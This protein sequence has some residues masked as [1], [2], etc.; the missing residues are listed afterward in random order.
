MPFKHDPMPTTDQEIKKK[1]MVKL[2]LYLASF[3]PQ[4]FIFG[5][6][7]TVLLVAV[8]TRAHTLTDH[9]SINLANGLR[10][11]DVSEHA[12]H[13]PGY[14]LVVFTAHLF[15]FLGS[16]L[17]ALQAV[18]I[19]SSVIAILACW[20]LAR[21]LFGP[22]AGIIAA[23]LLAGTPLFLYYA[24]IASVY[25]PEAAAA[26]LLTLLAARVSRRA[27]SLDDILLPVALAIAAGFRPTTAVL[28]APTVLLG[29]IIGRPPV[30]HLLLGGILMLGLVAT[31][32]VP[33]LI[34][35][36]GIEEYRQATDELWRSS[37]SKTSVFYGA[38]VVANLKNGLMAGLATV[39]VALP[40]LLLVLGAGKPR[41]GRLWSRE[42]LFLVAWIVPYA[43]LYTLFFFG[44][45]GYVLAYAPAFACVAAASVSHRHRALPV[46]AILAATF[47]GAFMFLPEWPVPPRVSPFL[48]SAHRIAVQDQ[49]AHALQ[50]IARSCPPSSCLIVSLPGEQRYYCHDPASLAPEYGRGA[51]YVRPNSLDSV[52]AV[53][54]L[55]VGG[56]PPESVRT[57]AEYLGQA[58]SWRI[59]Q[60]DPVQTARILAAGIPSSSCS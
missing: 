20:A 60:S 49:E 37:A 28:M 42:G 40:G 24:G 25:P 27:S 41:L 52:S 18:D 14:P 48:P 55:W 12:P 9:D 21:E 8:T 31:W 35:S 6:A 34:N 36:G 17:L 26:S 56:N 51:R 22:R 15:S 3:L 57:F 50:G 11:F 44:K 33:M 59:Y 43:L 38:P 30:R 46:A 2:R 29:L 32:L 5:V 47:I 19:L 23:L 16:E 45:P 53:R 54:T 7:L 58:G 4:T 10:D 13:P 1:S 39:V